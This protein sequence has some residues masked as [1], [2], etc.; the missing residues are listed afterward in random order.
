MKSVYDIILELRSNNSRLFKESVLE[1]EKDNN[2][3]SRA[4]YFSLHPLI[5]FYIKKIPDYTPVKNAVYPLSLSWAMEQLSDLSSRKVT[6]KAGIAHLKNILS[7]ISADDA[8]VIELIIAG[9]MDCGVS[10]ATVLK[11]WPGLIPQFPYMRC[12][13]FKDIK[14]SNIDWSKGVY[15]QIKSDGAFASITHTLDGQVII[16]TRSGNTFDNAHF[17]DI[18]ADIKDFTSPGWQFHGELLVQETG[19][20]LERQTG[21]GIL[22]SVMKGGKFG[23]DETPVFVCWDAVPVQYAVI[24]GRYEVP[25]YERLEY[26][27]NL[28]T[29]SSSINLVESRIV[30][31]LEEAMDHYSELVD[32]GHEGSI[33][34]THDAVWVDGDSK[35]Q[36]KVKVEFTC[37][38]EIIGL[39][40]GNGK[41]EKTFGSIKCSTSDGELEVNISGMKEN[42]R[43]MIF[44]QRET[45]IG[46][47]VEVK[48]NA[49]MKP[50]KPGGKHSLFLPRYIELR[51]D[52][53]EADSL[54]RVFDQF[55][56]VVRL[57]KNG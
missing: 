18:V 57:A 30:Y 39:N 9:D 44:D 13:Q 25:Y 26:I 8:K 29:D 43:Q 37:D 1:R 56:S 45:I 2:E 33:I 20:I 42:I 7:S 24:D 5:Q 53:T 28:F 10:T 51:E 47:I 50:K 34:K 11:T 48:A 23:F 41:N 27:H 22:G 4:F 35:Q 16:A 21:N 32:L 12:S 31:S 19:E 3:L 46:S 14:K 36:F 38:L 49:I 17:R 6:G 52:K 15:S 55:E 40:P 54:Q